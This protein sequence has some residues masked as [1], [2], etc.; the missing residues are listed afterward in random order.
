[1]DSRFQRRY[2]I[3]FSEADPAGWMFFAQLGKFAHDT[4]EE[5]VCALGIPWREWFAHPEVA[6]PL[7][8]TEA[9]YHAPLAAG[10]MFEVSVSLVELRETS[11]KLTFAFHRGDQL[12]A[13]FSSI[14]VFID[15]VTGQ[16]TKIPTVFQEKLA[17]SLSPNR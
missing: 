3:H 16:K 1:M 9:R 11:F 8:S 13:E 12:C 4:Y 2:R 17:N 7:R 15:K 14:H 5:W 10:E 6:I